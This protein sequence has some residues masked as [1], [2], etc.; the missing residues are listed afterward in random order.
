[1]IEQAL[2]DT[3]VVGW[4]ADVLEPHDPSRKDNVPKAVGFAHFAE[5]HGAGYGCIGLVRKLRVAVGAEEYR[6]LDC[7][8]A[9]TR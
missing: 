4:L 1:M 7:N 2:A 6:V 9:E 3:R 5:A 8:N